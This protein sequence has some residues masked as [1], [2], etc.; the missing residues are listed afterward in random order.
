MNLLKKENKWISLNL[1]SLWNWRI[2]NSSVRIF[3]FGLSS[4]K[5]SR[6]SYWGVKSIIANVCFYFLHF[7]YLSRPF[8]VLTFLSKR[9]EWLLSFYFPYS[10]F[11]HLF[12]L[13]KFFIHFTY[14]HSSFSLQSWLFHMLYNV[15]YSLF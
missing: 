11:S 15:S 3:L 2:L 9:A 12:Y 14:G 13:F 6:L 7:I 4:F 8:M 5:L 1:L 10:N